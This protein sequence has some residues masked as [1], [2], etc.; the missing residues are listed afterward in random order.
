MRAVIPILLLAAASARVGREQ[1]V[2][3][4]SAAVGASSLSASD[5]SLSLWSATALR[6]AYE[7]YATQGFGFMALG[8]AVQNARAIGASS[9]DKID[10]NLRTAAP[11]ASGSVWAPCPASA[12]VDLP[13]TLS[14]LA[15][16]TAALEALVAGKVTIRLWCGVTEAD[17]RVMSTRV[18]FKIAAI[19]QA[20]SA[21]AWAL[22]TTV[23]NVLPSTYHDG[24]SFQFTSIS[25]VSFG[26]KNVPLPAG[27]GADA[28]PADITTMRAALTRG[29][30]FLAG[31]MLSENAAVQGNALA[32]RG[33]ATAQ[34]APRIVGDAVYD[35]APV[36]SKNEARPN[37]NPIAVDAKVMHEVCHLMQQVASPLSYSANFV[38]TWT[39]QDINLCTKGVSQYAGSHPN[40]CVAEICVAK[41]LGLQLSPAVE[42]F[43]QA[44]GGPAGITPVLEQMLSFVSNK[45]QAGGWGWKNAAVL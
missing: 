41:A 11:G 14:G 22:P 13:L 28:T 5:G 1:R 34:G 8:G 15:G 23:V 26:N 38:P 10:T 6:R 18:A 35:Y 7:N 16:V 2:L 17:P 25:F 4:R 12:P 43:Y 9:I 24:R 37:L 3:A 32:A 20:A 29:G 42:T 44:Q 19:A 39:Q 45:N 33:G 40:E 30:I 21:G 36:A 27:A 31:N